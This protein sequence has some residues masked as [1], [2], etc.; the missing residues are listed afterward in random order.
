M[1]LVYIIIAVAFI[2]TF[3]QLPIISPFAVSV[4]A[5]PLLVGIIIGMYSFSNMLGNILAGIWIDRIG[6]RRILSL[7]MLLVGVILFF[8]STVSNP[9]QLLTVRFFHGFAGGFIVP[10]AFTYLGSRGNREEKG[11]TMAFSGAGVGIAA[12][13]GPALGAI[14]SGKLGYEGLFYFVSS[15]M[16]AFGVITAI[17]LKEKSKIS[18]EEMASKPFTFPKLKRLVLA[19]LSIFLLLYT[20]G[21]LTYLLPFKVDELHGKSE[22]TGLLLSFF[23]LIAIS[24]F[25]LPTNKLFDQWK[26]TNLMKSGLIVIA[27]ALIFLSISFALWHLFIAMAI[28]GIGF[29][30]IFPSTSASVIE[31]SKENER[32]K[33]FGLFYACFSLGVIFGSFTAGLMPFLPTYQFLIGALFV[34]T[35]VIIHSAISRL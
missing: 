6:S 10:A 18:T 29:A 28:Y 33:A 1:I 5:S 22:I 16:L 11:K 24:L 12:I 32:G 15:V 2:D 30:L 35:V 21:L 20:L 3:S 9:Y 31:F 17:F 19:Y 8:Y 23:G 7:G 34:M 4:G 26:K 13:I 25:I 27:I 14:V